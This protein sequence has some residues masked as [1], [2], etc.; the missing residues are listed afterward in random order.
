[1]NEQSDFCA[2]HKF[3]PLYTFVGSLEQSAEHGPALLK[4]LGV[5]EDFGA[6]GWSITSLV[7]A[8]VSAKSGRSPDVAKIKEYP[9]VKY[10]P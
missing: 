10:I 4:K 7:K 6:R 2:F 5:W 8:P 9:E 1:M 3:Y